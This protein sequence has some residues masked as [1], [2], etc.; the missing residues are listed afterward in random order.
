MLIRLR[1]IYNF[2]LFHV[3]IIQVLHTF[4]NFLYDLFG[5][6]YFSSA[7]CRFLFVACFCIAENPY[8][9]KSKRDATPRRLI[10]EYLWFL[11]GGININ[12]GSWWAQPTRARQRSQAWRGGLCQP[13]TSVGTILRA[14]GSLYQEKK[15]CKKISAIGV[16][17][18]RE[19][20]KR[21][22]ARSGER[23][24]EENREGDPISEGLSPLRR[25]GGH[26]PE[27]KTSSH[28]G[29]RPRK[30]KEGGSLPLSPG[31]ASKSPRLRS[32]RWAASTILLPSTPTLPPLCNGVRPLLPTIIST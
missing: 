10:L 11:G 19:Y 20:K 9:I 29:G 25:H 5:L 21:F 2:W 18:L 7:Q 27:G 22:L 32:W 23:K 3:N 15:L 28:L 14:Q 13:L 8:Q 1:R 26:G 6:T 4:G 31:G 30:K 12:G 17:D 16:T 24:T